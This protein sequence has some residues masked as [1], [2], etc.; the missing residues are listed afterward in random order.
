MLAIPSV[1]LGLWLTC[2][3]IDIIDTFAGHALVT[4]MIKRGKHDT[5]IFV[6]GCM[7]SSS[8]M[9]HYEGSPSIAKFRPNNTKTGLVFVDVK[10]I[11]PNTGVAGLLLGCF[12]SSLEM[13]LLARRDATGI[14]TDLTGAWLKYFRR[15]S[16]VT[17]PSSSTITRIA[18][19]SFPRVASTNTNTT[20]VL[21]LVFSLKQMRVWCR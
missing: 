5:S 2:I 11:F 15:R 4:R 20:S 7:T 8:W 1:N 21:I 14:K 6:Y 18:P 10:D 13:K 3:D 17:A 19:N 16:N 12:S 9:Q